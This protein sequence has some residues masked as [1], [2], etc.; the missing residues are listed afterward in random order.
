MINELS[1]GDSTGP[2]VDHGCAVIELRF[3]AAHIPAIIL[4]QVL[5]AANPIGRRIIVG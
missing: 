2:G 5:L 1:R 3:M 4:V